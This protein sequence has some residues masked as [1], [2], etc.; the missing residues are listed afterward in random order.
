MDLNGH[1]GNAVSTTGVTRG[2]RGKNDGDS[3]ISFY[4]AIFE[5]HLRIHRTNHRRNCTTLC[6]R[7]RK[8]QTPQEY[9]RTQEL[10]S[11]NIHPLGVHNCMAKK[12]FRDANQAMS[13]IMADQIIM[14][15]TVPET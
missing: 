2:G 14:T 6:E 12:V 11:Y 5:E 15:R 13:P 1:S 7:Y 10:T 8:P 4:A 9:K 3:L